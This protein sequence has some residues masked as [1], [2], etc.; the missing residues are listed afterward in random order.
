M[1]NS[2]ASTT[3]ISSFKRVLALILTRSN[4]SKVIG[5][6][7]IFILIKYRNTAIGVR[8]RPDLKGPRGHPLLGNVIEL[9]T[10][11]KTARYEIQEENHRSPEFG[12]IYSVTVPGLGRI[13]NIADPEKLDHVLRVNFWAYE[14]G[15]HLRN[16]LAPL[17]GQDSFGEIAFG[18]SFGCLNNPEQEVEFAAAFDRLNNALS[19]RIVSPIWKIRD[20]WTG[21]AETVRKDTKTVHE[22]AYGVI[23]KRRQDIANGHVKN[24][25]DLMQLF[26]DAR[27]EDG[28][29]LSDEMLKDELINMILAGRDTTAQALS[30]MFY[31]M[32]RS[33]ASPKIIFQ[34]TEEID[35]ILGNKPPTYESIKQQKYA[36]A[37]FFETLRLYPSVPQNL[38]RCVQDDVLPGGIP[39]YK[40][41][42]I[43]WCTWAMGRMEYLWGDDAKE[44]KPERWLTG[45]KPSSAKFVSFHL[46]PRTCLGKSFAQLEAITMASM[47][48][49]KFE[50]ELVAP[51][52]EPRYLPALTLPMETGLPVRVKHRNKTE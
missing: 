34:L 15:A 21:M 14:K 27:D 9:I 25:N 12:P 50:F 16:T 42:N 46:G 20:W 28:Q 30:W 8:P 19:E 31:A 10:R 36:E 24:R 43:G 38:K 52:I 32:H 39:V 29:P 45:E 7:L 35:S 51:N 3:T 1:A 37:C 40:G 13:I 23:K 44:F 41:E 6:Y 18:Q 22:F 17:V 11:P 47:L 26:M 33:E 2:V 4:I 48:L 49:Q 5:A